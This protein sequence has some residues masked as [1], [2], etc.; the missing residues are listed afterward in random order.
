MI[1]RAEAALLRAERIKAPADRPSQRRCRPDEG[2]GLGLARGGVCSLRDAATAAGAV[3]LSASDAALAGDPNGPLVF[4]GM[5]SVTGQ[6]YEM[7][8]WAG[9]YTEL[10]HVGAFAETLAQPDLDVPLVLD[11]DSSRR[12]A[13]TGNETSP[14]LLTEVTAGDMTGLRVLAPSLQRDNP[15]VAQIE[16]LLRS[17]L[18]DEMSFRFVITSG[19]WSDDW[20]EYHIHAVDIHRGDV[21]IV[22]YGANPH[23]AGSGL[24]A[25][26]TPVPSIRSDEGLLRVN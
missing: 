15:W 6:G 23:T 12:L 9:P 21:A 19:R 13:R 7:Y 10:V 8:D 26:P 2:S 4:E 5:A 24:R 14:L 22:G 1:T 18:I 11:H 20:M 17:G 25:K 16:P 3:S